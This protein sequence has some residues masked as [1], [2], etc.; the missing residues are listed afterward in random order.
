MEHNKHTA[1]PMTCTSIHAHTHTQLA[2]DPFHARPSVWQNT[3]QITK[4]CE[5][6][7]YGRFSPRVNYQTRLLGF[8]QL[9]KLIVI[10]WFGLIGQHSF[11]LWTHAAHSQRLL[12]TFVVNVHRIWDLVILVIV[13]PRVKVLGVIQSLRFHFNVIGGYV[14]VVLRWQ[15]HGIGLQVIWKNQQSH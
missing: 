5:V 12:L 7:S 9:I 10:V 4:E 11:W 14:V 2:H 15:C 8:T 3:P 13:L 6:L 1:E